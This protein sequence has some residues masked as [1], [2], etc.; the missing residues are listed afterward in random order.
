MLTENIIGLDVDAEKNRITWRL[1]RTDRY[2]VEN[3]TCGQA[4]VALICQPCKRDTERVYIHVQT[5]TPITLKVE[6]PLGSKIIRLK[7]GE[8]EVLC[9]NKGP[10]IDIF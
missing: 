2:G 3:L 5:D 6:H 8:R 4:K 1:Q 10:L 7:A 9:R